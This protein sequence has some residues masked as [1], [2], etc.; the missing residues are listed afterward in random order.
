MGKDEEKNERF[1]TGEKEK[2]SERWRRD[3]GLCG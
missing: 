3:A 1:E 2:D